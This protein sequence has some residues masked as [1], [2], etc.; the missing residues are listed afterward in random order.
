[1][2]KMQNNAFSSSS[3]LPSSLFERFGIV[4]ASSKH[5][6]ME[7]K[8][9]QSDVK[10][11]HKVRIRGCSRFTKKQINLILTPVQLDGGI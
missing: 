10:R 4:E 1:M 6:F 5:F 7:E 11:W 2:S 3:T 9:V 8:L